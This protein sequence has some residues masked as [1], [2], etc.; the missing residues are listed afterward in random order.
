MVRLDL[1]KEKPYQAKDEK[2]FFK[3]IREAFSQ[4]R[5]TLANNLSSIMSKEKTYEMLKELNIKESVRSE[6][7]SI[8]DFISISDYITNTK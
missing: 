1:Y 2:F 8:I 5:K 7:L 3:L 4:R 6:E